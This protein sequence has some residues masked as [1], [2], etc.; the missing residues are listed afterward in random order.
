MNLYQKE[1]V[2]MRVAFERSRGCADLDAIARAAGCTLGD[3]WRLHI[4]RE[5][6]SAVL[7]ESWAKE[8]I[9]WRKLWRLVTNNPFDTDAQVR[10]SKQPTGQKKTARARVQIVDDVVCS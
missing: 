8:R 1:D 3:A 10:E 7:L 4:V 6:A 2:R 9:A 5:H